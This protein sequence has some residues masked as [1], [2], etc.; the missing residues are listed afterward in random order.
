MK[1]Y[2]ELLAILLMGISMVA[3][4]LNPAHG[5]DRPD[6]KVWKDCEAVNQTYDSSTYYLYL[7]APMSENRD[8]ARVEISNKQLDMSSVLV[9]C[10]RLDMKTWKSMKNDY[11]SAIKSAN[12]ELRKIVARNNLLPIVKLTCIKNG[13]I[14]KIESINPKCPQGY[15]ELYRQ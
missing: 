6:P 7:K 4:P 1:K 9:D 14:A 10:E 3:T 8:L 5:Q 15:K 13:K 11:I 12:L 2:L